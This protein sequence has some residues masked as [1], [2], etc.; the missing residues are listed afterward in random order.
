MRPPLVRE[1]GRRGGRGHGD[2]LRDL[3]SEGSLF[4]ELHISFYYFFLIGESLLSEK[5]M[6]THSRILAWRIP[7]AEE[8]GGLLSMGS[9][10]VGHDR[11]DLAAAASLLYNVIVSAVQSEPAICIYMA[12]PS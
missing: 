12:P 8:P 11:S 1:R 2:L 10:R 4:F 6:A 3:V 5:E 9:H 7:W